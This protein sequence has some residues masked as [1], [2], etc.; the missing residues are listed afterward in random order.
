MSSWI[1]KKIYGIN[2][3]EFELLELIYKF[4]KFVILNYLTD[5]NF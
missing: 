4:N 1:F 5:T 2:F 3:S